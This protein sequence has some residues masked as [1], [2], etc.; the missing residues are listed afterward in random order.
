MNY[1]N[2][3]KDITV[4]GGGLAGVCAAISAARNGK[5]VSLVQNRGI[6]GG[7]SSS[8]IRV[9]VCGATKHGVNRYARE[10]GIMGEL[11]LE[12]QYRNPDGNPYFWDMLLLE[13]VKDEKNISLFL[14]TEV[15]EID[16]IEGEKENKI[17]SVTG[18]TIGSE[19]KTKF[20]SEVYLDCSGDGFIGALAGAKYNLGRESRYEYNELLAPEKEDK[21]LLGSTILFYTKDAGH[22]VKFIPPNFAKDISKTSIPK[23]RVI[24]SNDSGCCYWWIELGGEVDIVKDNEIIRDELWTLVYGI[25]DYIKNSGNYDA[26]N[27]TLEWVGSIPGKREYR[28]LIGDYVLNQ[29]DII[30]Q[31]EFDDRIAFGG[32]SIDL[33]PEKGIY[34]ESCGSRN[35]QADGIFHIPFRSTYS[36]NVSNLMFAGRNIS[37]SHIAFGATRVMATCATIGEAVGLAAAMCVEYKIIPRDLYMKHIK[38]LQQIL[39]KQDGSIIGIKNEDMKDK[40]RSASIM[41]STSLRKI[42]VV[43]SNDEYRL[44]T[45]IGILF[46]IENRVEDI[47]ILISS[48]EQTTLEV[49]VWDTGRAENYIPKNLLKNK[50]VQ[51]EK[52]RNQWIKSDFALESEV[53]RNLFLVVK[54]NDKVTIHLSYEQLTGVLSFTKKAIENTNLDDYIG[55]NPIVEWSMKEMAR[56]EFCFRI[57]GETNAYSPSKIIDGYSRPY[58]GPHMWISEDIKD[59]DE[60]IQLEWKNNIEIKEIH[61]TFNDDVNEDLINLHHHYT[62]F[63]VVPELVKDY[64]VSIWKD[65]K[66]MVIASKKN[67]RK[68]KEI[69]KDIGKILASKIRV[70]IESTNGCRKAE[71][72]EV[73][74]Y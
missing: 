72:I 14:N 7:N 22:P 26:D 71:I 29:N 25:W 54:A 41:A 62:E 37:A 18:W 48:L 64:R 61:I 10:T 35:I 24:K 59:T 51:V 27:L 2:V 4:I 12:N 19:T 40:A 1:K 58:G 34:E 36:V 42:E 47:E 44:T 43:N 52:G 28:R 74:V 33:H 16:V 69:F 73:R 20:E 38:K 50:K 67:N 23:N 21:I 32:W 46:P 31:T 55:I 39:L 68:R 63:S 70:T 56:K 57:H 66:W 45:D 65:N 5:S 8:E 15:S 13:K 3:K 49:E 6:L 30:E 53:A 17:K 60:W 9:W 11:F